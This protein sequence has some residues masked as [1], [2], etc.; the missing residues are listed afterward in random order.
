MYF[1]INLS[2]VLFF[3]ITIPLSAKHPGKREERFFYWGYFIFGLFG[4]FVAFL[5]ILVDSVNKPSFVT[6]DMTDFSFLI[7][8]FI[9]ILFG[10]IGI[11]R[12]DPTVEFLKDLDLDISKDLPVDRQIRGKDLKFN[13]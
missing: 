13:S 11:K 8:G 12:C 1:Y 4:S 5:F 6:P 9:F 3:V 10:L 2:W 7:V